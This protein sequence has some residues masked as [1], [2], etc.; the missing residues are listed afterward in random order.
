[1]PLLAGTTSVTLG[2]AS[3]T[4][5]SRELFDAMRSDQGIDQ[6]PINDAALK[7]LAKTCNTIATVV[8]NHFKAN[9]TIVATPT[10]TVPVGIPVT[11]AGSAVAQTGATTAPST[12]TGTVT[13]T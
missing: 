2:V 12:A 6:I 11:T 13:S 10:L 5:L 9:A 7:N 1:M 3:G 8:I 4:G